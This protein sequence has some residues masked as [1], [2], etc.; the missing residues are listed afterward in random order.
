[1]RGDVVHEQAAK[2]GM[3]VNDHDLDAHI[4]FVLLARELH[5]LARKIGQ[6]IDCLMS[7]VTERHSRD[8]FRGKK[9]H[10]AIKD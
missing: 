7:F 8:Y 10:Q 5:Q 6:G 4:K 9:T 2:F 3:P 1:M